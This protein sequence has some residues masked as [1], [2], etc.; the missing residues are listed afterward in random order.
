MLN[1][2]GI[3]DSAPLETEFVSLAEH[4]SYTPASFSLEETPVLYFKSTEASAKASASLPRIHESNARTD[5]YVAS[6]ALLLWFSNHNTGLSIPYPCITLHA[7]QTGSASIYL[8]LESEGLLSNGNSENT[9]FLELVVTPQDNSRI[10]DFYNALSDCSSLHP[11]QEGSDN[12]DIVMDDTIGVGMGEGWITPESLETG[13]ADDE[14][15]AG[16]STSGVSAALEVAIED[17][18]RAGQR[19]TRENDDDNENH[20]ETNDDESTKW[21]KTD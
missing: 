12:E 4:Q 20:P 3:L 17:G 5:I 2:I 14:V 9:S 8:Q 13:Q 21:R 11:D 18:V 10:R 1:S 19:R 7:I 15:G 16:T 6:N